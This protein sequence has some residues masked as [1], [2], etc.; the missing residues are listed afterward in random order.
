MRRGLGIQIQVVC[1]GTEA[2]RA[3]IAAGGLQELSSLHWI[4]REFLFEQ[5]LQD[6][7][8]QIPACEC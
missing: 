5:F 8:Y 1:R 6:A 7:A 3:K 4:Y 2:D